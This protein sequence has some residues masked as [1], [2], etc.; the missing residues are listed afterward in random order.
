MARRATEAASKGT[1]HL[2]GRT[3]ELA[4][5][6]S[7]VEHG[8]QIVFLH[9]IAGIGKSA[10]LSAF[11]E[12]ARTRGLTVVR[13]DCSAVEPTERGFLKELGAAVGGGV[14]TPAGAAERLG[15]LGQG[16]VVAL[17]S[18][19]V[20]R[21][22]DAWMRR[23]LL[24]LLPRNVSLVL[25][26]RDR[27]LA[28]WFLESGSH[29]LP[30]SV[31]LQPLREADALT[32]LE[33]EGISSRLAHR[34][35]RFAGGHPLALRLAAAAAPALDSDDVETASPPSHGIVEEL[36]RT[37]LADVGDPLTRRALEA[38]SVLRRTT[39]SLLRA[40]LPEIAPQ[41]A[42]ERLRELPFVESESDGLHL[43]DLVRQA[44]ALSLRAADPSRYQDYRRAAWRQ[45]SAEVRR[46]A[47][48]HL[49]RYT[50]DLLYIIENPTLREAFFPTGAPAFVVEPARPT[51]AGAI[52]EIAERHEGREGA[53]LLG[54]WWE[55]RSE[56]FHAVRDQG[57]SVVG[58]YLM[59]EPGAVKYVDLEADPITRAWTRH[60]ASEPL[61]K[62]QKAL[63]IRRWLGRDTGE[64]A[65]AVQAACWLDV[66]RTYMEMRPHLRRVY[67]TV[68]DLEGFAPVARQLGFEVLAAAETPL[69]GA[70]YR[71]AWID[72]GPSSIDGWLARLVAA[73]LGVTEEDVLDEN[74]HELILDGRR[75]GLTPLEY[76]VFSYLYRLEGKAVSRAA[77]IENVWGYNYAGSNVVETVVRSLRKK[78]EDRAHAIETIRGV[79]YRFRRP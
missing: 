61:P 38:A 14:T 73:E 77:L 11:A 17:D 6:L 59:F 48:S 37:Y 63:F 33:R 72:F 75:I 76:S 49:W 4:A 79:G 62:N 23:E 24:P 9:G 40:M 39:V 1:R 29:G 41:D 5:L 58:F 22:L 19:E 55:R 66:K 42:F 12:Q 74:A 35:N 44:I 57:G 64:T 71:T 30:R 43:Q 26:G 27:P 32:L 36:T 7:A 21:L 8:P 3:D 50:A 15:S 16:V 13:L 46:A 52:L 70:V 69:D 68:R 31:A 65:S 47:P 20:F 54:A 2:V 28:A 51:D 34:I 10:L 56:H 25:A 78:L 45:L 53:G 18:Y 67:V 60:L